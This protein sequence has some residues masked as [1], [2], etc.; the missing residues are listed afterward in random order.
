[1][2][3]ISCVLSSH[4]VRIMFTLLRPMEFSIKFD[5]VKSG[6]SIIYIKGLQVIN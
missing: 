3:M 2:L 6:W 4:K 5:T 1:M